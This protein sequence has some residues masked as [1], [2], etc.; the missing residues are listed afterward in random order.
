MGTTRNVDMSATNTK[1]KVVE[2]EDT[3]AP[4]A[5]VKSAR[6]RSG[7]YQ[8]VRAKVDKT[9]FYDLPEAVELVKKL[10]YSTFPGSVEAHV[11]AKTTGLSKEITFPHSTGKSV[12]VAILDDSLLEQISQGQT[13]FDV[14]LAT[15]DQMGKLTKHAKLL[16]PK[17]LMPNPKNGTLTAEPEA[18]KKELEAGKIMIKTE[19]KAPLFHLVVGKTSQS[20]EEVVANVEHL[21][22]VLGT[23]VKKLSLSASMGPG[24]KVQVG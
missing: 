23:E 10:A 17:G 12:T 20:D 15:P 9:K 6:G 24:V 5:Q 8:A 19:K 11:E 18:K 3:K 4:E 13:N 22:R 1:V 16:G 7:K 2:A 21:L 14:L